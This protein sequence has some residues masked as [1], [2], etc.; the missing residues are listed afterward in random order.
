MLG[1][2]LL[3]LLSSLLPL[4][5]VVMAEVAARPLTPVSM[6]SIDIPSSLNSRLTHE[7]LHS[8]QNEKNLLLE[9]GVITSL[10]AFG[11]YLSEYEEYPLESPGIAFDSCAAVDDPELQRK[12][13]SLK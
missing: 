2:Q 9:H 10:N 3:A 1:V 11:A 5:L 12:S 13:S 8:R 7:R 6:I 4:H